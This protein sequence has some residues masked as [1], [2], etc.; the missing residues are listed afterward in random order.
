MKNQDS[1]GIMTSIN[2]SYKNGEIDEKTR[3]ELID[4][5]LR[6]LKIGEY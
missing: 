3:K 4:T 5:E 2:E 1:Y 6:F